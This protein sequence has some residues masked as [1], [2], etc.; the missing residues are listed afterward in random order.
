MR[1]YRLGQVSENAVF[2]ELQR[3]CDTGRMEITYKFGNP[4]PEDREFSYENIWAI[5]A[6][7][8]GSS[9]LVV[10]PTERQTQLLTSLLTVM[11]GPFWILYVLVVPRGRG[12]QG[13]Y[14]CPELQTAIAVDAFLNLFRSFIQDDGR[15]NVWIASESGSEML[16]YDRHNVIY[17]YGPV[18]AFRDVLAAE[19]LKEVP[20]VRFPSPHSHH[21]HQS[22]DSEEE[23]LLQYWNWQR[24][25]LK[26]S[27]DE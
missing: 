1:I 3:N 26:E 27:D 6:T 25:P 10:A 18:D 22:L 7:T 23:R 19:G 5:E 21:Y 15:H 11:T 16:I 14:Q 2:C 8:G 9:R 13:R 4:E 12:E 24:S 17:A 20:S